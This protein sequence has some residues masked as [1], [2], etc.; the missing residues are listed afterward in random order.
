MSQLLEDVHRA[1][2]AKHFSPKIG[3]AY[4]RWV[5]R[6]IIFHDKRHPKDMGGPEVTRFLS[7]LAT[8]RQVARPR[9]DRAD[10]AGS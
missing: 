10:E 6:F 3:Q 2:Q 1:I 8:D 7:Y 5:H 9:A 4:T